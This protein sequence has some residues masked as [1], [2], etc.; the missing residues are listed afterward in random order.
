M[1]KIIRLGVTAIALML[2]MN[3]FAVTETKAQIVNEILKRMEAHKNSLSS[4]KANITM[5]KYQSQLGETDV[6]EGTTLYLPAKGRD[7]LVRIDWQKPVNEILSVVN[8]QYVLYKPSLKQAYTGSVKS[9]SKNAQTGGALDFMNMSK[10]QLKANYAHKYLGQENVQGGIPTW[11]LELT[12]KTE[13]KFKLA[14]IW[15]DGNGMVIQ[16][17]VTEKNDDST[18]VLLANLQKNITISAS[19]FKIKLPSDTKIIKS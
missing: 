1:N 10:E 8:G 5:A 12:P 7:A 2:V 18:T 11:H 19:E 3:I 13:N 15:I 17:K 14:D 4:L 6:Y 9:A 16:A